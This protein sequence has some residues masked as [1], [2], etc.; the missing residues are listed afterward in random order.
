M[1]ATPSEPYL[2]AD[3]GDWL[4]TF[5]TDRL[6]KPSSDNAVYD[7]DIVIDNSGGTPRGKLEM[8][9]NLV[10]HLLSNS[11]FGLRDIASRMCNAT[12]ITNYNVTFCPYLQN[13]CERNMINWSQ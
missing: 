9:G 10:L 13:K 4:P 7:N 6:L 1:P 3:V 11:R 5:H 2:S 8:N 12:I